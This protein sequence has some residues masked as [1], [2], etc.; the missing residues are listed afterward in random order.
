MV[1]A[2]HEQVQPPLVDKVVA[3]AKKV[4]E[5]PKKAKVDKEILES[6]EDVLHG[7][8][9]QEA[10]HDINELKE[11]V[12]EHAEDLIEVKTLTNEYDES[13]IAK[14]LRSRVNSMITGVDSLI[15]RLESERQFI[16]ES[17]RDPA[18]EVVDKNA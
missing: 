16:K 13:K 15:A 3:S 4:V 12:I 10:R 18:T 7:N 11:K 17:V 8:S 5:D 1:K 6:L 9:I 2:P 14:R